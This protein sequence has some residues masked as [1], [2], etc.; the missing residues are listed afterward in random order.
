T[1]DPGGTR[2]NG[3]AHR[4]RHHA[5]PN[6]CSVGQPGIDHHARDEVQMLI[7]PSPSDAGGYTPLNNIVNYSKCRCPMYHKNVSCRPTIEYVLAWL[8]GAS[9]A[10]ACLPNLSMSA[11]EMDC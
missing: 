8:H 2:T 1:C 7:I 11:D 10:L 4:L 3:A 9:P 5:R 6:G